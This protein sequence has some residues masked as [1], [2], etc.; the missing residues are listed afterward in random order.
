MSFFR[1]DDGAVV[2][3]M[4]GCTEAARSYGGHARD[5]AFS[6]AGGLNQ[7]TVRRS[8]LR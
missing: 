3:D 6:R 8:L 2:E 1:D 5:P 7:P 4:P